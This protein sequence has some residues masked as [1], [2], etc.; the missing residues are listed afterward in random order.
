MIEKTVVKVLVP[1]GALGIPYDRDALARGLTHKPDLIAIDGG[2]T[3]SGP[4]Y[5]GTGTS[6]YSRSSTKSDWGELM[7]ARAKIGVP[8][9]IG[10]AGTCGTNSTVD[11]LVDIT[12]EI[13]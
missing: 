5:L 8:L 12:K 4:F 3:D 11:W 2:S 13:A 10:T 1:A 9:L 6:K 7:A